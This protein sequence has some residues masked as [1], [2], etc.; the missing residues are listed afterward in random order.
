MR[1]WARAVVVAH[2]W[3]AL[4]G[5][6][7]ARR[8]AKRTRQPSQR[9]D[10][11]TAT[12]TASSCQGMPE[13]PKPSQ[14]SGPEFSDVRRTWLNFVRRPDAGA[15]RKRCRGRDS[16]PRGLLGPPGPPDAEMTQRPCSGSFR[17]SPVLGAA[18]PRLSCWLQGPR[19]VDRRTLVELGGFQAPATQGAFLQGSHL[20]LASGRFT[21]PA[22]GIF[23][24]Y[25]CL[26][27]VN[28]SELQGKARP[29][30]W[31][32][33]RV[34]CLE[35]LCQRTA[36]ETTLGLESNSKVFTAQV[37]GLLQ[38][39][40]V[41]RQGAGVWLPTMVTSPCLPLA[42]LTVQAGSSFSGLLPGT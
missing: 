14:A 20:S 41:A 17:R 2:L 6:V 33:V 12:A 13:A 35:S 16:K 21:A 22:S 18:G 31:G 42:V 8:E 3:L 40:D 9:G 34:V 19:R 32:A 28:H 25:A 1:R 26:H 38:L 27:V 37:Q 4:L 23:Q 30:V 11:P 5:G 24:F 7:G 15:L 36:L 39:A 29:Q 10:P